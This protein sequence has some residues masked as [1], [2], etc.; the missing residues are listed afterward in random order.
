[1]YLFRNVFMEESA[2]TGKN[3]LTEL[4]WENTLEKL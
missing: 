2:E 4:E 1:M 3:H